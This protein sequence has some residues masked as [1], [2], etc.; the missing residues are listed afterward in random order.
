M[1]AAL[2]GGTFDPIHNG[3]L[4]LARGLA[5]R[6]GLDRVV[7]MPTAQPPH[8]LKAE[9]ASGAH[10]AEM[11]RLATAGDP[12]FEVSELEL[13]R[14]GASFTVDTLCALHAQSPETEWYLL[15]GADMFL[16]LKTWF[17]FPEIAALATLCAVPRNG[18]PRKTLEAYAATLR[19]AGARC[20]VEDV[21]VPTVSSTEIRQRVKEGKDLRSLVPQA[22]AEYIEAHGLYRDTEENRAP[23]TE[24]Q[25]LEILR[26]RLT[27][28]R[29]EHSLAVAREARRLALR[30]GANPERAYRAGLLHD[31]LKDTDTAEQLQMAENFGIL[32]DE[33]EQHAPQLWHARL[34]AV[35]CERILGIRD[36]E[37]C[38]AIR[39]HTT[40][41]AGMTLLE[42]ILFVADLTAEGRQY[43][44]VA[45]VRQLADRSLDEAS[46]YILRFLIRDLKSKGRAVH[47]DTEAALAWL[48]SKQEKG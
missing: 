33:V 30:Y 6:L 7:L 1:R 13:R 10:R 17:R 25:L 41:R 43:P 22:V 31:I 23:E 18:V 14:G 28:Y 48:I 3:H 32:F 8:K 42:E 4:A 20:F 11:C 45:T 38:S 24:E 46:V 36:E 27:T 9:M 21:E 19:E 12:L 5:A 44:D 37:I 39:Y 15:T 16:T 26:R 29:L 34:G 47:P 35:F 2:F 40:G